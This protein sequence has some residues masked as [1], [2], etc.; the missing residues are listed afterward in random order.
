ML[1]F[2][3]LNQLTFLLNVSTELID[4]GE[5]DSCVYGSGFRI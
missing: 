5:A 3:E 4:V 1:R 2:E